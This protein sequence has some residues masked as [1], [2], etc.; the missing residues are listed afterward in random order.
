MARRRKYRKRGLPF[1]PVVVL[2]L[3]CFGGYLGCDPNSPT[4][5]I[6]GGIPASTTASGNTQYTQYMPERTPGKILIGSFNIQRLGPSQLA[7]PWVMERLAKIISQFDVIAIQEVTDVS[8]KT[9]PALVN[10]VNQAGNHYAYT[11]S[12]RI[13]RTAY[14]EQYAFVFDYQRVQSGS[15]VSYVVNDEED[16][17]HREPYVGRFRTTDPAQPF[18]FT[19]INVHTDPDEIE[20]ELDVLADLYLNVREFEY[21]EDDVI[22]LGDFNQEPGKLQKLDRIVGFSSIIEGIPTNTRQ[23]KTIDNIMIDA[24]RTVE[25][26]G[27]AGV[28]D[29]EKAFQISRDDALRLSDHLPVWAEFSIREQSART[30]T[31]TGGAAAIR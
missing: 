27:R 1:Y 26:S 17:L 12:P 18:E 29:L 19:L 22:L 3:I 5:M 14:F 31:F 20:Y 13:G 7:D 23:T 30:A 8:E 2:G 15:A 24:Q 25:F 21:P 6:P 16:L 9:L 4:D 11:I 10:L 28:L